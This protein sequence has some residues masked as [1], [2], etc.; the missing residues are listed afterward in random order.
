MNHWRKGHTRGW[1]CIWV[2]G[3]GDMTRCLLCCRGGITNA[4]VLKR[5]QA[6]RVRK[7]S[8]RWF[9]GTDNAWPDYCAEP[10]NNPQPD[11]SGLRGNYITMTVQPSLR[12]LPT[13]QQSDNPFFIFK[14]C[15][16]RRQK[17]IPPSARNQAHCTHLVIPG[18]I[19]GIAC[20]VTL[21]G[22]S[23]SLALDIAQRCVRG[24]L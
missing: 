13:P 21:R 9:S 16:F 24:F 20:R 4:G 2:L 23:R 18:M 10:T 12:I 22:T 7:H 19:Y 17:V 15:E 3:A 6:G 11:Q 8:S 5:M 1:K 14:H